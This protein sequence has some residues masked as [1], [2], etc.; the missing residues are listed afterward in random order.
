MKKLFVL[1]AAAAAFTMV[2]CNKQEN[3][4]TENAAQTEMATPAP[5]EAVQAEE[6][7]A[8]EEAVTEAG[9]EAMTDDAAKA[10]QP[11]E[12]GEAK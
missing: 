1:V 11:A 5:A 3:Q 9:A 12:A 6:A 4:E 2:S 10:E 8:T 7:P